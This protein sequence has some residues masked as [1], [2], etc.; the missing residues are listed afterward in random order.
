MSDLDGLKTINDTHGHLVG[1][2]AIKAIADAL[3]FACPD[4][5]LLVRLGGDEMF[6]LIPQECS[7]DEIRAGV[8]RYLDKFNETSDLPCK[9]ASSIGFYLNPRGEELD[10]DQLIINADKAMYQKKIE[11]KRNQS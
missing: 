11:R 3:K 5:A 6:A 4:N 7:E 9:V 2:K 1:D 10:F 8:K